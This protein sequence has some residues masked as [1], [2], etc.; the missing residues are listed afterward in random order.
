LVFERIAGKDF[1]TLAEIDAMRGRWEPASISSQNPVGPPSGSSGTA[2]A[3]QAL[4]ALRINVRKRNGADIYRASG[5]FGVS[6]QMIVKVYGHHHPDCQKDVGDAV[7][8]HGK[9]G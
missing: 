9:R 5:F 6:P 3:E 2:R 1:V 7:T 4:A 8:G